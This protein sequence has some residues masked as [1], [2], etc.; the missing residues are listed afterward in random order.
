MHK[1]FNLLF[2][3]GKNGRVPTVI[4]LMSM[5]LEDSTI[6]K[7]ITCFGEIKKGKTG[8]VPNQSWEDYGV[9]AG[10]ASCYSFNDLKRWKFEGV[11]LAPV[12]GDPLNEPDTSKV[13]ERAKVIYNS[14]TKKFVMWMHINANDYSYSLTSS[15]Q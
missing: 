6:T 5:E 4:L 10:G 15:K 13:I 9:P 3:P 2:L 8:L 1:L 14:A 11:A 7:P 12:K